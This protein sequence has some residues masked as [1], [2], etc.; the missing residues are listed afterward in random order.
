MNKKQAKQARNAR[1]SRVYTA[2]H[3]ITRRQKK[4]RLEGK[5]V[6]EAAPR[7]ICRQSECEDSIHSVRYIEWT[8]QYDAELEELGWKLV[9]VFC[10]YVT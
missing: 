5:S 3:Y 4:L 2:V 8:Q 1:Q 9:H 10:K 6:T 7:I